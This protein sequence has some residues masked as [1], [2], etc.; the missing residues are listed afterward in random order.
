MPP[1]KAVKLMKIGSVRKSGLI[2]DV[3]DFCFKTYITTIPVAK[4]FSSASCL[5]TEY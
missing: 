1:S 5:H 3:N 4:H 2:L